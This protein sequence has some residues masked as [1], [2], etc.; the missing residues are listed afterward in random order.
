MDVR[1]LRERRSWLQHAGVREPESATTYR[2]PA[3]DPHEPTPGPA[4]RGEPGAPGNDLCRS[5][6]HSFRTAGFLSD[7]GYAAENVEGGIQK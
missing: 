7:R 6:N 4:R 3:V 5:S 1:E 2:F